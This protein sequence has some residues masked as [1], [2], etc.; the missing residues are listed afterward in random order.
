MGPVAPSSLELGRCNVTA[1]KVPAWELSGLGLLGERTQASGQSRP[2]Q[3]WGG[4]VCP[5]RGHIL[6]AIPGASTGP[7][8]P[9]PPLEPADDMAGRMLSHP[10]LPAEPSLLLCNLHRRCFLKHCWPMQ[11]LPAWAA[12]CPERMEPGSA[13]FPSRG[14]CQTHAPACSQA[15]ALGWFLGHCGHTC[16]AQQRCH[17]HRVASSLPA[18]LLLPA[19]R[20]LEVA[21]RADFPSHSSGLLDS[22]SLGTRAEDRPV[23]LALPA[24]ACPTWSWHDMRTSLHLRGQE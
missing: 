17:R 10:H 11:A 16:L 5:K 9:S 15:A 8:L 24:G 2:A 19:F 3:G 7:C 13:V 20:H 22:W 4:G 23:T 12:S 6:P 1:L 21:E 18:W 14:V